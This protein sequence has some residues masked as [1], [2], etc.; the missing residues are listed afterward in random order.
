[1]SFYSISDLEQL[2]G[3]K[4][5]TIRM[6][7]RRYGIV[8]PRRTP[9][10]IRFYTDDDLKRLLNVALLVQHGNKISHVAQLGADTL[11]TQVMQLC[12]QQAS[13]PLQIERM[14]GAMLDFDAMAF[15]EQMNNAIDKLGFEAATETL[16]FPFL[17]RVGILWQTGAIVPAHEHFASNLI[18]QKIHD[19]IAAVAVPPFSMPLRMVFFLPEGESHDMSLLYFSLLA[20]KSGIDVIYLGSSVPFENLKRVADTKPIDVFFT[21][22][23]KTSGEAAMKQSLNAIQSFF[24]GPVWLTGQPGKTLMLP[25]CRMVTSGSDFR[26]AVNELL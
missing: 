11:N 26:M 2:S 12:N 7:E 24:T 19:A 4:A 18:R 25:N 1:M 13:T 8:E 9:T 14:Q 16:L 15:N 17:H 6:W 3:I 10:N 20:R 23:I 22:M 5:H 21:A